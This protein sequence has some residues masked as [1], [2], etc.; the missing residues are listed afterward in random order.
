MKTNR[1]HVPLDATYCDF[2]FPESEVTTLLGIEK[3]DNNLH[4]DNILPQ[5]CSG[6]VRN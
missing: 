5:K 4:F 6:Y 3:F 1:T 2:Q